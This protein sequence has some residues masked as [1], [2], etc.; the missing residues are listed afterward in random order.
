MR[1]ML[2]RFTL[3]ICLAALAVPV[4]AHAQSSPFA[5]LPPAQPTPAP[6]PTVT[7]ANTSTDD[8]GLA[9]WQ[10]ILIFAGGGILLLGIAW[11][12]VSDARSVAPT[13]EQTEETEASR[14]RKE[15]DLK[16][17]K[18][19]NRAAAKRSRAS[20]KKNR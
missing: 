1:A 12:I 11:A 13:V 15:E 19:K 16:R 4:A 6:T 10:E 20:R 3:L 17:R 5:P 7:T 9:G 8:D 18:A 14:A 2:R